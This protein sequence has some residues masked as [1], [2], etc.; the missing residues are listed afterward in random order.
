MKSYAFAAVASAVAAMNDE[1]LFV[2]YAARF[3]KIYEDVEEFAV[4]LGRF[5]HNHRVISEHNATK[6][7]FTLG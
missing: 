5:V 1:L 7:N 6:Q 2:H 4:R 3:N